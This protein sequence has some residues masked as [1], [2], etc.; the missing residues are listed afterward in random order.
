VETGQCE[1]CLRALTAKK[2]DFFYCPICDH[3]TSTKTYCEIVDTYK[4]QDYSHHLIAANGS[5]AEVKR[6]WTT[7]IEIL[8]A[9]CGQHGAVL[10]VGCLDGSGV[11]ALLD[12]GYDAHGFD[13][14]ESSKAECIAN[15]IDAT[16]I[17]VA[18][19]L[20]DVAFSKPFRILTI[21][22]VIEHVPDVSDLLLTAYQLLEPG[23]FVMVQT[24]RFNDVRKEWSC[25]QHLRVYSTTSLAYVLRLAGFEV[26]STLEWDGG[27]CLLCKRIE[28]LIVKPDP[29][30][31]HQKLLVRG[32]LKTSGDVLELGCGNY[33]T[34]VTSEICEH[35]GRELVLFDHHPAWVKQFPGAESVRWNSF[36]PSRK[37]GLTLIDHAD[38]PHHQRWKQILKLLPWC[39]TFVVHDADDRLYGYH[40]LR[41]MFDVVQDT[42]SPL[43][44]LWTRK[45]EPIE[46]TGKAVVVISTFSETDKDANRDDLL[47]TLTSCERTSDCEIL[48]VDDG[49]CET[50]RKWL[51]T[52]DVSVIQGETNRGV[53]WSKNVALSLFDDRPDID[54]IFLVDDDVTFEA[55]DWQAA[56]LHGLKQLPLLSHSPAQLRKDGEVIGELTKDSLS[57]GCFVAVSRQCHET[58]G[59]YSTD[60]P[61]AYGWEHIEYYYRAAIAGLVP[62]VGFYD[63]A[64]SERLLRV[65]HEEISQTKQQMVRQNEESDVWKRTE[66][67]YKSLSGVLQ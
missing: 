35:Q 19:S 10:E 30:S 45:H 23:G 65:S 43:T 55:S 38:P 11:A 6:Q 20:A 31:T 34:P 49:S 4:S 58:I 26:Q 15:G 52:L 14:G 18:D 42:T 48:I 54:V 44:E 63:I 8:K 56:Y 3:G 57:W 60:F 9:Q 59:K 17:H 32:L 41:N 37:F 64:G 61:A 1:I 51:K 50:Y 24:P 28:A 16:R 53:A 22:E 36:T 25:P 67:A 46:T 33:S 40:E 29:Y 13:V 47:A 2:G 5:F 12:A 66:A 62:V 27:V 39:D 21:R 7:N